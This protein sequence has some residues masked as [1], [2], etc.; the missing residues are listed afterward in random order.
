M[1][2]NVDLAKAIFEDYRWKMEKTDEGVM[3]KR[4]GN[5]VIYPNTNRF[6]RWL[7][8]PV[9]IETKV[10]KE[11]VIEFSM[12]T[13]YFIKSL[14]L[15]LIDQKDNR[16][17]LVHAVEVYE[18]KENN[19]S[20][21]FKSEIQYTAVLFTATDMPISGEYIMIKRMNIAEKT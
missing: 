4:V 11:Y 15:F 9:S 7:V 8:I 12:I 1:S 14:R 10:G 3:F 13:N 17:Q 18:N 2:T 16:T 19:Y 6:G 20:I 21:S 5:H